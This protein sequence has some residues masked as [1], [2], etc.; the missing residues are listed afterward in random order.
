MILQISK[1]ISYS[2]NQSP[3]FDD[4]LQLSSHNLITLTDLSITNMSHIN[5]I[6]IQELCQALRQSVGLAQ[7][8]LANSCFTATPMVVDHDCLRQ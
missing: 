8:L 6:A 3:L 1:M 7:H 2:N 4:A 5:T